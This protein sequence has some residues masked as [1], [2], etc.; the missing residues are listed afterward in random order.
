M[1]S[2]AVR[3]RPAA[4]ALKAATPEAA[5][6]RGLTDAAACQAESALAAGAEL[7]A[8]LDRIHSGAAASLREG[9][10]E[11]LTVL[12]LNVGPTVARTLRTSSH[13]LDHE[14]SLIGAVSP[15]RSGPETS[16]GG[17]AKANP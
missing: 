5:Y 6:G 16:G 12:R 4:L 13:N 11:T 1:G 9:T 17:V 7:D 14:A 2:W 3:T 10:A 15:R 8:E